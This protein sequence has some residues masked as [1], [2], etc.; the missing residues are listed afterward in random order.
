MGFMRVVGA[1]GG[2]MK[3]YASLVLCFCGEKTV[4][5]WKLAFLGLF[6]VFLF[7]RSVTG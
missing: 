3:G 1:V 5:T 2:G 4:S 7:K 6:F